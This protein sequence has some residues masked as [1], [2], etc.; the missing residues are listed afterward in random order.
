[1]CW[2]DELGE[3][4][5]PSQTIVDNEGY[6]GKKPAAKEAINGE[7][8]RGLDTSRLPEKSVNKK[9]EEPDLKSVTRTGLGQK[10]RRTVPET[11]RKE[12]RRRLKISRPG[13]TDKSWVGSA[14]KRTDNQAE[15]RAQSTLDRLSL[16][17]T[18][19]WK[20]ELPFPLAEG[21]KE[22]YRGKPS[23]I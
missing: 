17:V 18:H 13:Q 23:S 19:I 8:E 21:K 20:T 11:T 10:N 15:E 1:V 5:R 14:V 12:K 3:R 9:P 16:N 22:G 4:A 2:S 6:R 7:E